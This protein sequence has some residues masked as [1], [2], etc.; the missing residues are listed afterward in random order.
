MNPDLLKA[1]ETSNVYE[2]VRIFDSETASGK[3][4]REIHASL[5]APVQRV[6]NPPF[7][8]P[9]LPKMYRICRELADRLNKE[10]LIPLVRLE[11]TEYAKRP[12]LEPLEKG[13]LRKDKVSF[14]Q[15]E[16]ALAG[17]DPKGT[18]SLMYAF[19]TQAGGPELARRMLLLGSGYFGKSLGHSISCTA[20]IFLEAI[21]H[22]DQDP[23]PALAMIADYFH[24]GRFCQTPLIRP[25]S[26]SEADLANHLLRAA[27]GRGI[28]NLHHTITLYAIER[29]RR[30]FNQEE[31]NHLLHEWID[32][33]G[34]KEAEVVT[35]I[36]GRS[37]AGESAPPLD[38]VIAGLNTHATLAALSGMFGSDNERSKVGQSL[39]RGIIGLYQGDYNPH[40]LTGLGS[41][42]WVLDNYAGDRQIVLNAFFQY[43][44][45]FYSGLK[46]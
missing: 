31:Y 22:H 33:L 23:W 4:P 32:F 10:D 3:D 46:A 5:F 2:A 21:E 30:L 36:G 25:E 43:L 28:I 7:I 39:I 17:T 16:T 29:V 27:S 37:S 13:E 38:D 12:K 26:V 42:L 35:L 6:L 18:A 9:H 1:M 24:K 15:I 41:V 20:F 40:Y 11:I 34:D 45:Y 14:D 8:N 44:D 19:W